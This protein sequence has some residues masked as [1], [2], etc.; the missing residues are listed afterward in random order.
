VPIA[1]VLITFLLD[2]DCSEGIFPRIDAAF[3]CIEFIAIK[4]HKGIGKHKTNP[5][6]VKESSLFRPHQAII[7]EKIFNVYVSIGTAR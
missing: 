2:V 7:K 6:K 5:A 4:L 1:S 3:I